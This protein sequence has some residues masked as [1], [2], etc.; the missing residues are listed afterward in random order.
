[1][2]LAAGQGPSRVWL[3]HRTPRPP[4]PGLSLQGCGSPCPGMDQAQ[5]TGGSDG[6]GE[7]RHVPGPFWPP[8]L[9]EHP[10]PVATRKT[11]PTVTPASGPACC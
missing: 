3:L 2:R 9:Q 7:A 4:S 8:S 6:S 10:L 1:M 5:K 11:R